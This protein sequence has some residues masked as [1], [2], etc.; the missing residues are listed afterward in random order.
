MWWMEMGRLKKK[1]VKGSIRATLPVGGQSWP[2]RDEL[3]GGIE[4]RRVPAGWKEV[5]ENWKLIPSLIIRKDCILF[6][7]YHTFTALENDILYSV[8]RGETALLLLS[9]VQAPSVL[10]N[11]KV[12]DLSLYELGETMFCVVSQGNT[13]LKNDLVLRCLLVWTF[14]C[15]NS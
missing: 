4:R 10:L 7:L 8:T 3:D 11:H 14:E 6:S 9:W 13:P 12:F 1:R 5:R 15:S 2:W